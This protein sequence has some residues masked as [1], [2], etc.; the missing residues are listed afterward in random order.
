MHIEREEYKGEFS[1]HEKLLMVPEWLLLLL[2]YLDLLIHHVFQV[3]NQT[4]NA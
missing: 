4:L 3:H 1:Y 2:T